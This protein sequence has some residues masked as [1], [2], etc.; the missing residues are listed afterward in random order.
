MMTPLLI[1]SAVTKPDGS[2]AVKVGLTPGAII[3]GAIGG[4]LLALFGL[5][6][7]AVDFYASIASKTTPR[8]VHLAIGAAFF[9][10]GVVVMFGHYVTNPLYR[11]TVIVA[12]SSIPIIGGRRAGDPPAPP[13]P[14][15]PGETPVDK[16]G[17]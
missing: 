7:D 2:T 4:G 8:T 1:R 6:F 13:P 9:L 12:N 15:P 3:A 17:G 5:A 14:E 11:L 16:G 10:L